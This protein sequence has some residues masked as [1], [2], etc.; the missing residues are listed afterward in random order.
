MKSEAE[1]YQAIRRYYKKRRNSAQR[2]QSYYMWPVHNDGER[3]PAILKMVS[4]IMP[5]THLPLV[6]V[7]ESLR[8]ARKYQNIASE[9]QQF[10]NRW[11][12]EVEIK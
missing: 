6:K 12:V 1:A 10:L 5:C 3:H 4:K 8:Q 9:C 2:E 7:D 11:K